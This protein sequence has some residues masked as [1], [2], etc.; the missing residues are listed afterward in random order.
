MAIQDRLP[1]RSFKIFK[2]HFRA[3]LTGRNSWFPTEL[4]FRFTW[5]SPEDSQ[6][7]LDE[8]NADQYTSPTFNACSLSPSMAVTVAIS[9][10]T[11]PEN[12]KP[13]SRPA[14]GL[15]HRIL[16]ANGNHIIIGEFLLEHHP[17]HAD[18]ILC[19]SPIAQA[20]NIARIKCRFQDFEQYW[21]GH[22]QFCA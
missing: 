1:T 3:H 7:R 16:F 13:F 10:R 2:Y 14:D 22:K 19:V 4:L 9:S 18:I 20:I 5:I 6:L 21:R 15:A 17:L 12:S 8:N 11:I